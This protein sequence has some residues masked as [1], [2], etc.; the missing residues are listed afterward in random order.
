MEDKEV[1]LMEVESV[2][3]S[4]AE[5]TTGSKPAEDMMENTNSDSIRGEE[6]KITDFG[7]VLGIDAFALLVGRYEVRSFHCLQ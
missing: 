2:L 3:D 7:G 4:K 1:F 5:S 6:N